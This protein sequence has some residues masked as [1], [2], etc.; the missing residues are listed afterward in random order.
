MIFRISVKCKS[1]K[2]ISS[3]STEKCNTLKKI[4]N[5]L[6]NRVYSIVVACFAFPGKK[7]F[8]TDDSTVL[9]RN[10]YFPH[11]MCYMLY[12]RRRMESM[13]F[14]VQMMIGKENSFLFRF[15][16]HGSQSYYYIT[17]RSFNA[18]GR[19]VPCENTYLLLCESKYYSFVVPSCSREFLCVVTSQANG[20]YKM[21]HR[22]W[23]W[24]CGGQLDY[25]V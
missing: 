17:L 12:S 5:I 24:G 18:C 9:F 22:L 21:S 11:V 2:T 6:T 10:K 15:Y 23:L 8:W 3:R 7:R 19:K 25:T 1:K 13:M 16:E 20:I 14:S 4:H